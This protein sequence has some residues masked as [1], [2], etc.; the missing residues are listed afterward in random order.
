MTQL[1]PDLQAIADLIDPHCRLLDVGCG[2][3]DLLDWLARHKSVDG[4][5]LELSQSGVNVCVARGLSVI[6]GDAD[7]D[8]RDYP[9]NGFDIAVLSQTLQA[10]RAPDKV[11]AELMR[12]ARAAVVSFPNFGHWGVRA[13]LAW[14]GTMP[15]TKALPLG[16]YET[17]NIHLCTLRDF[18]SLAL[19]MGLRIKAR[20]A[21]GP[22]G[23][24][25]LWPNLFAA[26]A[27]YLLVKA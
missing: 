5:G 22:P 10:T 7:T 26:S 13:H 16:W 27:I 23:L 21:F 4:R 18:E 19:S 11:L 20:R 1:R 24:T 12:I 3:G 2:E 15:V 14:H 8:L 25:R 6:Q 17:P 9:T